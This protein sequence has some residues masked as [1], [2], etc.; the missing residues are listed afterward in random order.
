MFNTNN[1]AATKPCMTCG[2]AVHPTSFQCA[3]CIRQDVQKWMEQHPAT[4]KAI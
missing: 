1:A 4:R 2:A 3:P